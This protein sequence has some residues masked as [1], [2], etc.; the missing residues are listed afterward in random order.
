M[1]K[2]ENG[3]IL[4]E[5]GD[6]ERFENKGY[7]VTLRSK[8]YMNSISVSRNGHVAGFYG[9]GNELTFFAGGTKGFSIYNKLDISSLEDGYNLM[10]AI[11]KM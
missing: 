6:K 5:E 1:M 9:W 4:I 10:N 3:K 8:N 2:L 11:L 7:D